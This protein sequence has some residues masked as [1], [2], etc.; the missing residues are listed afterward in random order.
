[1]Y[2]KIYSFY[3]YIVIYIQEVLVINTS[4]TQTLIQEKESRD[5]SPGM[6]IPAVAQYDPT[7]LRSTMTATWAALDAS[8]KAHATPNHLPVPD[9]WSNYK[10]I[11]KERE[12]KGLPPAV[13]H[14]YKFKVV[15]PN[16]NKVRW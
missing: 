3:T 2:F 11:Q 15:T 13:G 9:W 12:A 7:G 1:M 6:K 10:N 8:L 14:Q 4:K 16:Y 5:S